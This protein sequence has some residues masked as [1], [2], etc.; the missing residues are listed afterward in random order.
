MNK[1]SEWRSIT[2]RQVRLYHR[3]SKKDR[4]PIRRVVLQFSGALSYVVSVNYR[5]ECESTSDHEPMMRFRRRVELFSHRPE[6]AAQ[7]SEHP[8][9]IGSR[10]IEPVHHGVYPHSRDLSS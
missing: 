8:I 6:Y 9:L 2:F 10:C 4:V 3:H 7:E 5:P 1:H